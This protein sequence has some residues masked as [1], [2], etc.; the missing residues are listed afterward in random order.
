MGSGMLSNTREV[1]ILTRRR[2]VAYLVLQ[3]G[4][5]VDA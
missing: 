5:L 4:K 2:V 1:D 3:I